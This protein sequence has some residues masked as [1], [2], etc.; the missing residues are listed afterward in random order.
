[1]SPLM[2]GHAVAAIATA[3]VHQYPPMTVSTFQRLL[4]I[5]I[6]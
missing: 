2:E 5:W 4:S 6:D 3:R 1:M